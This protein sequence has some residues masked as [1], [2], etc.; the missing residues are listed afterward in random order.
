MQIDERYFQENAMQKNN[1]DDVLGPDEK[2]LWRGKPN[3]KSYVLAAVL[4]MLPI[5]IIWLIFDGAFI[6]GI[7][8]GMSRGQIPLAILGFIIPFFLLH[9]TPVWI[10][11]YNTVKAVREVKNLEY[12]VTDRRIIIRSGIIGIDF[13]FVNYTEIDSVNIKVGIIDR[14]FKVGD[15]YVNSSVNSAVL[16]D[17]AEPYKIGQ[18]LQ[19]V[20]TDIKSDIYYPNA[21]RPD[22]NPGYKTGYDKNPFDD[23]KF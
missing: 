14:I 23:R 22:N 10:W 4:K 12:A 2:L 18:A 19:K 6:V 5:A 1:I 21:K 20:I 9:L 7:S 17:V 11:I 13:K 16:W 3:P 8:I 15:I